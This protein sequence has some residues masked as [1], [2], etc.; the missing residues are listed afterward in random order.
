M[1]FSFFFFSIEFPNFKFSF[2]DNQQARPASAQN[3]YSNYDPTP[4]P[5]TGYGS[6][7][8][9]QQTNSSSVL[10]RISKTSTTSPT[11]AQ[12]AWSLRQQP[13]TEGY[14]YSQLSPS[15]S[16]SGPTYT[17]LSAGS[18]GAPYQTT[19]GNAGKEYDNTKNKI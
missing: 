3:V 8:A 10:S 14:N 13:V 9:Q 17:Q 12:T 18:R 5:I 7:T 2:S 19:A 15:R 1:I 4:P 11:P 6:P 16:P